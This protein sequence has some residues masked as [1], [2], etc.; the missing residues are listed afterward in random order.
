MNFARFLTVILLLCM[1]QTH[2]SPVELK[3]LATHSQWLKLGHYQPRAFGDTWQSQID[4]GRFFL[5][6]QGVDNPY[7]EL[8]ATLDKFEHEQQTQIFETSCLYPA[9]FHWLKQMLNKDWA[10]PNCPELEQWQKIIDPAGL[11]LVFPTSFINNPSSAFGHTLLRIDSRDQTRDKEL[12]AFAVN[13]AAQPKQ[14]DNALLYAVKGFIGSYP[15][16]FS[17]MPYHVKVRE[18]NDLES[19]DIWE[20]K[21]NFS[22]Q[23]IMFILYHLWELQDAKFDYFF[24]DENCSYQLISL[25]QVARDDLI[26]TDEF[27]VHAVPSD[28][29]SVLRVRQLIENPN[30]RP[31]FGTRINHF[32]SELTNSELKQS[33]EIAKGQTLDPNLTTIE[34]IKRLEMAYEVLNFQFY[35]EHLP[36]ETVAPKL[37]SLLLQ[38]S[39][40]KEPSPFS[41]PP[42]PSL[43]PELGHGSMRMGEGI[44]TESD[45]AL[46]TVEWRGSYHDL[47]DAPGGFVPGAKVTFMDIKIAADEN[48]NPSLQHFY[49][50]DAMS[51]APNN[52]I[53][54]SSSW[55]IR[56]GSDRQPN[57]DSWRNRWYVQ[58]GY[59][60]SWGDPS[61][62][63]AY[64]LASGELTSVPGIEQFTSLG[65]GI[66]AGI[67]IAQSNEDKWLVSGQY[68]RHTN[69]TIYDRRQ[70][71]LKW[72]K[73]LSRNWAVRSEIG[74]KKWLS[75]ESYANLSL[76]HYY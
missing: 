53:F 41:A 59:G 19:R 7:L 65:A 73:V 39:Q 26:L 75:E 60:K 35:N 74:Y 69:Q 70:L 36:R 9:R 37:R 2:A 48:A 49:L 45:A 38:R 44:S 61:S 25:L 27:P 76:L 11:T 63:H 23:E 33:L 71:S 57:G 43:S 58:N 29:V 55:N 40:L 15:G 8:V 51:L 68:L 56:A 13:F 42:K 67:N 22:E 50:V 3:L 46:A 17:L 66:E 18:Y 62:L 10:Q 16:S 1:S 6:P 21:L 34:Q 14:G 54:N 4:E 64:L 52:E 20:Y 47:L 32:A 30:Y 31:A 28:T 5:S 12:V 24:L 72:N